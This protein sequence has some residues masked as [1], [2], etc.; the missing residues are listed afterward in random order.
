VRVRASAVRD[1]DGGARGLI[2][3]ILDA[4]VLRRPGG[5]GDAPLE[6]H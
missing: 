1:A 6:M 4:D 3:Q 2:A 5:P